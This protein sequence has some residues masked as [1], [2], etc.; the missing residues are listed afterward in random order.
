MS[1]VGGT[2]F[3]CFRTGLVGFMAELPVTMGTEEDA[4]VEGLDWRLEVLAMVSRDASA[5]LAVV[6]VV[7][8]VGV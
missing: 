1:C 8:G 5:E 3:R 4:S 6:L 2:A 7:S